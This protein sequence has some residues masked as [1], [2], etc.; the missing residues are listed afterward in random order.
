MFH[1]ML[2]A[3]IPHANQPNIIDPIKA[4]VSLDMY[5]IEYLLHYYDMLK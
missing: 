4:V 5:D 2:D 1:I 3:I